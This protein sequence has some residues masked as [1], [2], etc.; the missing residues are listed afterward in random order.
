MSPKASP[1]KAIA[2]ALPLS[3]S[4]T[5]MLDNIAKPVEN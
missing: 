2:I 5:N 1:L 4:S 3:R